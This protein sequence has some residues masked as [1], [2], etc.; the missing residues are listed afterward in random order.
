[1]TNTERPLEGLRVIDLTRALAGPYATLLLAG[2]GAEVIKIEDPRGGDLARENS[3]YVGRDGI[4]VERRHEDDVSVSHLTR[5][6][7][8]YGVA[9]DFKKPGS[10]EVFRDLVR[11]ADIV[12]E[13]FT[14]GTADRLGIGY[15]VARAENPGVIYCSLSGFGATAADG[16][17]MDIII[18]ALSGAMFASGGHDEPPV[19]IGIPI[20][21]MLAP[22]FAVIGILSALEQRHRT[23]SGQHIDVS[24]L[25]AL[26][27][28]V[29]IEN[30][31]AMAAAG[32]QAR[33]GLT[34]QRLSPFGVFECADGY[35]AV[36]AVHEKLAQGLFRAMGQPQLS[37]DPRF[38]NRDSRVANAAVLEAMINAWSRTLSK[39][40]VVALLEAEGVPVAPVRHPEDALVDPRVVARAETMEVHH[41]D[42]DTHID[43]RTAGIP[44]V[45]SGARTGF[46]DVL[47]VRVGEH[48]ET[49]LAGHLGYSAEKIADL[50]AAGVI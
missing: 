31:S 1:M 21:D 28:F 46:D 36:V 25:G 49:I 17:A 3:P 16:K 37:A 8:K 19:R 10:Q 38:A 32:M 34:V 18:Q 50:R 6:R 9:L 47:P 42:Y 14:A 27:S 26:T 11:S 29:A 7:G 12:V 41:P 44:I 45:F 20:A 48:A 40:E 13:N 22:V 23:G 30:W 15:E 39:A 2:L 5:A 4:G 33:T 43:L 35:V 24:M